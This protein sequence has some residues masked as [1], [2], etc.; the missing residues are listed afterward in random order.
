MYKDVLIQM[1]VKDWELVKF[2]YFL[3][4]YLLGFPL[5]WFDVLLMFSHMTIKDTPADAAGP[6]LEE[7]HLPPVKRRGRAGSVVG[8]PK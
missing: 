6:M 2:A 7:T 8:T 4:K 3:L 1:T 5:Q